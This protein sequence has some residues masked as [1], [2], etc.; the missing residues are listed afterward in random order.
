MTASRGRATWVICVA[1]AT[2]LYVAVFAQSWGTDPPARGQISN[3]MADGFV[4][5]QLSLRERPP[6][7]LLALRDPYDPAQNGSITPRPYDLVLYHDR[8][9]SYWGPV[10]VL[11]TFL[12]AHAVGWRGISESIVDLVW[13]LVFLL[14][15][16]LFVRQVAARWT[17]DAPAWAPP[18]AFLLVAV[19]S[20][21]LSELDQPGIYTLAVTAGAALVTAAFFALFRAVPREGPA[22]RRLLAA[23][24]L[25]IGLAIGSRWSLAPAAV[26]LPILLVLLAR[27]ERTGRLSLLLATLG[28][29]AVCVGL[30]GLYNLVRFGSPLETGVTLTLAGWRNVHA[31]GVT[32]P[33]GGRAL[34]Y[35]L[36]RPADLV[37]LFPYA[38]LNA[39]P[40]AGY[41][42]QDPM[43]GLLWTAPIIL[44]GPLAA[45]VLRKKAIGLALLTAG[46]VALGTVSFL[47]HLSYLFAA[48]RYVPDFNVP[49]VLAGAVG[50]LGL[51]NGRH[52][53]RVRRRILA[54][55]LV[56][57]GALV[58]FNA[59]L[60]ANVLL[61]RYPRTHDSI[62]R[63]FS[64]LPTAWATATNQV[65]MRTIDGGPVR[66]RVLLTSLQEGTP[67]VLSFY[68]PRSVR[69]VELSARLRELPG[70]L[71]GAYVVRAR[72]SSGV[73][74]PAT[75]PAVEP[76]SP[77]GPLAAAP[78]R[79]VVPVRSGR[80]VARLELT[81]MRDVPPAARS[82]TIA[83]VKAKPG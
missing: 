7:S 20:G 67:G 76:G 57:T 12:P 6:R 29:V 8:F 28:P 47:P 73:S 65:L 71:P 43:V 27:R 74:P 34:A 15:A 60:S 82:V 66:S 26:I 32:G 1:S 14:F 48:R 44:L 83:D 22:D 3:R 39:R 24:S 45:I 2:A 30:L 70:V 40:L 63:A 4:H 17:P 61:E 25:G 37:A 13:A 56:V 64:G 62:D 5:G 53:R 35:Y 21:V 59:L 77:P 69:E 78:T 38:W 16:A 72:T 51:L 42:Y 68:A 10:P 55:C 18:L 9:Y 31:D 80:N 33:I 36:L 49:L 41:D 81:R 75:V 19:C 50:G 11:L 58:L 52:R 46:L 79:L 23:G 54:A